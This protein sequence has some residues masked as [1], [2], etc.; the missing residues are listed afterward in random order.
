MHKRI[1][2]PPKKKG[3]NR[4]NESRERQNHP[5]LIIPR[6]PWELLEIRNCH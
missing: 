1:S 4:E 5:L 2:F 6:D 3:M